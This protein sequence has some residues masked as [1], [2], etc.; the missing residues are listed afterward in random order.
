MIIAGLDI[1]TTGLSQVDGHRII[2]IAVILYRHDPVSGT[3]EKVGSFE[4]RL[5]PERGI[6]AKAQEIHGIS[7]DDLIGKPKWEEVAPKLA[8]LLSMCHYVVMHNGIGFDAPFLIGE[9][10]RVGE[11][12]PPM[13]VVDTMLDGRWATP[14]GAIPNLGALCFASGVDYDKSKAH[15]AS[16]D[17]EVMMQCFFKQWP[18]GFFSLPTQPYQY[19]PGKEK[20]K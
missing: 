4:Q 3:S 1:E 17:V 20:R 8:K 6:D 5:N 12:C 16:Y 11:V 13:F 9:F 18:L 10:I 2:E 19:A 7:S 14:D 15:G